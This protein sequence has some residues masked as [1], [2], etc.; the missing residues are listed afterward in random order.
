MTSDD[1]GDAFSF[2]MIC[3]NQL[4]S[5]FLLPYLSH[6]WPESSPGLGPVSFD[7]P[8]GLPASLLPATMMAQA[9]PLH[10]LS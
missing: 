7:A 4:Q 3:F 5:C 6:V 9:P 2:V 10:F 1:Q 8:S